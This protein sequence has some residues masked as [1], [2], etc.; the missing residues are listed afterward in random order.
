MFK[1]TLQD[2]SLLRD[3]LDAVSSMITE[4]TFE[5]SKGGLKLV[6]MDSASVAMV[7]LQILPSAFLDYHC[8]EDSKMTISISNL[9]TIM[10]RARANDSIM[11]EL[12]E[13]RLKI[14][15]K[16][17]FTRTFIVPLID[18]VGTVQKV[19]ELNFRGKVVISASALKDG[20][21]D[22]QMI[23]DCVIFETSPLS[24]VIKSSGDTSETR[25]EL[26]KD[27]PS[28]NSLNLSEGIE[29]G[30]TLRAKYSIDYIDKM[31]KGT[32]SAD[33][34]ILQFSNDYPM[35]LDHTVVDKLQL[36]F[37]LAPRVDT[38]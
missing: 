10:K 1:A 28:L 23:S 16:G 5:I 13:N 29:A 25:M 6:A 14:T 7:I 17:D 36:S 12:D 35:K 3:N 20:I 11:L 8:K 34:V 2:V 33:N 30:K 21:K 26:T 38:D 37:I 15:M 27:S 22:A 32:K 24:F 9:V 31:L 19:P 18:S 4:G